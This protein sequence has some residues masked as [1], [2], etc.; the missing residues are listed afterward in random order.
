M[1][2]KPIPSALLKQMQKATIKHTDMAGEMKTE[3]LDIITGSI[4][5]HAGSDQGLEL[6]A[7]LI[8]DTLDRQHGA[9]WHCAIGKGF[10]FDVTAQ[11]GTL[12]YCFYQAE[13]AIL[14][15]KC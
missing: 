2:G 7:R 8:K 12:M 10:S 15:Y 3:V 13:F 4:D 1:A 9:Q 14:V 6:A 5:K 11:N